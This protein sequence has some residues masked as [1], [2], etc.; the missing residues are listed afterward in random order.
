MSHPQFP[1]HPP[2][3]ER[4]AAQGFVAGLNAARWSQQQKLTVPPA[5]VSA[6]GAF[7]ESLADSGRSVGPLRFSAGQQRA[8]W[9]TDTAA[10]R[11][12]TWAETI[13]IPIA[14]GIS[15]AAVN[16]VLQYALTPR[17]NLNTRLIALD[18]P[19]LRTPM[20]LHSLLRRPGMR[21]AMVQ[22]LMRELPPLTL[23]EAAQVEAL[24]RSM[25]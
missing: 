13:G 23:D 16:E 15:L 9:R 17:H 5:A 22:A 10:V 6:I 12:Q 14:A 21:Y 24:A 11:L 18:Q 2:V 19:P 4:T 20:P 3:E 25:R 7:C 8:Q 1:L